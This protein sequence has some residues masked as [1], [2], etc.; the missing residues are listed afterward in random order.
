[1]YDNNKNGWVIPLVLIVMVILPLLGATLWQYS[2]SDLKHVTIEEKKMQ[3][4]FLARSGA[5]LIASNLNGI[6]E[7]Q[8]IDYIPF[9]LPTKEEGAWVSR[10]QLFSDQDIKDLFDSLLNREVLL[11]VL[12]YK[13]KAYDSNIDVAIIQSTATVSGVSETIEIEWWDEEHQYWR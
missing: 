7:W 9:D 8:G 6:K 2:I 12:I 5:E 13:G 10:Q 3:A 1:M 11:E 4:H